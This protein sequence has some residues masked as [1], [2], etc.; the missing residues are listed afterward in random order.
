MAPVA[1]AP[2]RYFIEFNIAMLTFAVVVVGRKY[3]LPGISDPILRT[4]I[5]ASPV[6]PILL[7]AGAVFRFYRRMDEY[8]KRLLLE[9]LSFSAAVTAVV[10]ASWGFL[11][12]AGLPHL[13]LFH[14]MMVMMLCWAAAAL[15]Q[16][17]KEKV[18]D[19]RGWAALK[20][21]CA[22]L[23]YVA[24]GTALFVVMGMAAGF[25]TPGWEITLI[26]ALLFIAR[27]GVFIFAKSSSC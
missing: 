6:L 15:F 16:G 24:S 9:A 5:M 8:H 25:A 10:S 20:A 1:Q 3:A 11:E 23:A 26:A 21:A 19:G 22:T 13:E 18:S 2:R 12:D 4:A 17:F 27:A 7:T 14:A